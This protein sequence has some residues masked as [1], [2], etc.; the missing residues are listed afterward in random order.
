[1]EAENRFCRLAGLPRDSLMRNIT[2]ALTG[3]VSALAISTLAPDHG[4]AAPAAAPP[5]RPA[6]APAVTVPP[7][8]AARPQGYA[9]LAERLLP[10]VV[11]ISTSQTLKRPA[12]DTGPEPQIT[13]G[14]PLDD[15][16]KDFMDRGNRPR[17]VQS[18][19]SG[20]VID[21]AG[22]IVTNNHV[23]EGAD[24]IT[25][26]LSDSTS[27][28]AT[29]IGRDDKTDLAV[30]KVNSK[31]PL[32]VARWGD[33][34]RARVG[35]LVMAIGDPFGLGGTVTTG[36][37]SARNRDINSGPY[38]DFIQTDAPINKGNSGGPLF[39]MDGEVIGINSAIYSP[40]GGSVGIGFA[41]PAN[42]AKNVV[43]QLKG[44]GKIQRGWIGIRIQQV[45]DDIAQSVGL[46]KPQGALIAGLTGGGPAAK[47][48]L[49]NGDVV[50]NFDGKPVPDNRALP[51]MVADAQIGKTYNMEVLRKGQHKV[52]PITIQKL[53]E[54][55]K[56]ASADKPA[57]PGAAAK[58]PI[59]VNLGMT[60]AP[61]SPDARR[62]FHLDNRVAGVVVTDVDAD[63]PAGQKNIRAGDVITEV[64]QQKI[65]SPDD[66]SA[67]LD[68][69][70]K[71]G[72]KVVL[73]Q[74]SR[75][76]DLTFIGIRLQ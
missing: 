10:M 63:S 25:V 2:V 36:I 59:T 45:S 75:G 50:L 17:R 34:D 72:H 48:G 26:I 56:V 53:V 64:A 19:G 60:L 31:Q 7:A 14:S 28:P 41:I 40:S 13:P 18:L 74:V 52:L 30:L 39:N 29:L 44:T 32:A 47:A 46:T 9:D 8:I 66:V 21:P 57:K 61:I 73:L 71:A 6:A 54:D 15:F 35:D 62:R 58:P 69:E 3:L 11:N 33:S 67:K 24:E 23:I 55:E 22:Y 68:T 70:R 5:A 65:S 49:Q 20:F 27:L 37:V 4:F 12:T 42:S 43:A 51:R 38:D 76:G 16:F 1:M